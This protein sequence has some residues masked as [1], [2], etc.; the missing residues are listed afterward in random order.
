MTPVL[1]PETL[2]IG[3]ARGIFPMSEGRDSDE[4]FW[5]DPRR[6]G[7]FPLP[8]FHV[9]RS[10]ARRMR[11]GGYEIALDRDFAAVVAVC[12][13]REETW[14]N[15]TI[16]ALY[17]ALHRAGVAHSLEVWIDG[18]LAGG[19]YGVALGAAFF[20]ESMF[21]RTTDASKIALAYLND[22]LL[23]TGYSLFDV[24]F[25]TPHLASLGA[26]EIPRS[27]YHR[28]LGEA[29]HATADLTAGVVQPPVQEVLQ[30]L[31]QTS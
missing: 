4:L 1:T 30:R 9:S 31:T 18:E 6:R 11:R 3:Y 16:E 12:A 27:R 29:L 21:S 17:G 13:D 15:P 28:M 25:L 20:G 24:Q 26:V 5:V 23:R 2:L 8:G 22:L 10:L 14:I 7:I 19:V